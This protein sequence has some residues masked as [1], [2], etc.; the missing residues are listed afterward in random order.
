MIIGF[1]TTSRADFGIYLPLLKAIKEDATID[2]RIFAGGMHTDN[3]FGQSW[4]LIQDEGFK[5]H[6]KIVCLYPGYEPSD[7]AQSMGKTT[8][9]YASVWVK[10]KNELDVVMAMGDRFEMFA[11]SVSLVPFN[12]KLAH[13]HGGETTIGAID[14]KFRHAITCMADYHY[15]SNEAH[16]LKVQEMLG[17]KEHVY[18][19]GALGIDL[20]LNMELFSPDEFREKFGFDIDRPFVL[21]TFHPETVNLGRNE[22]NIRNLVEAL[23]T[24]GYPVLCTLP[25][26]DTEGAVIRNYLLAYEKVNPRIITCFENLGQK[27]YLTAMKHCALMVGN[28]SSGIIEAEGFGTPVVNVGNRQKGRLTGENVVH[29]AASEV[30]AIAAAIQK[31]SKLKGKPMQR[32][33][34]DGKA[35]GRILSILKQIIQNE[36]S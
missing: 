27:G 4:K 32:I 24:S 16:A 33:Y 15:T 20:V 12:I 9:A 23:A 31:A 5:V 28:T 21:T 3:R 6:E 19:V 10:Y 35:A 14:N 17:T 30:V 34:G 26:A 8:H 7:I 36:R 22:Q 29:V 1:I 18:N 13:L 25:N 11:A 2:Y